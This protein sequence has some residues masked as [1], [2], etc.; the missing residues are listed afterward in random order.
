MNEEV[1]EQ[2][3]QME[4]KLPNKKVKVTPV[5][6]KGNWLPPS[7]AASFLFGSASIKYGTPIIA[8]DRPVKVLTNEEEAFLSKALDRNLSVYLKKEDNYWLKHQVKLKDEVKIL[9]L[10]DPQD[11]LDYKL[12]L[13]NK[14]E[15][16]P[17][18]ADKYKKG[19]Y[20]F[21]ISDLEFEDNSKALS[22]EN[23]LE[24]YSFIS[25]LFKEGTQGMIDFLSTYYFGKPGKR[26]PENATSAWLKSELDRIVEN[27]LNGFL[28]I[29]KDGDYDIKL[30][31][32]KALS[33][34]IVEKD[35]SRYTLNGQL[36]ATNLDDLVIWFKEDKNSEEVV[37]IEAKVQ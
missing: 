1:K 7:H 24:A 25:K 37:K 19:T 32:T 18:G 35:N 12:L 27:D 15:I 14:D 34:R 3:K 4:F 6:R 30:L 2:K 17:T 31:I 13:A 5:R 26:V 9:D 23:K 8:K 21:C 36:I 28:S 29:S 22:L 20:R 16:A 11:Y 33:K 10:S